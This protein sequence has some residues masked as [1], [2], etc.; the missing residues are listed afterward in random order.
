MSTG[1]TDAFSVAA[2][3][4]RLPL[5]LFGV[6]ALLFFFDLLRRLFVGATP[7]HRLG[8]FLW[9]GLVFG[10]AI[11]LAGIGLAMTYSILQFANFAHGDLITAGA[12]A[13]W[14]VTFVM[15][16]LGRF[17]A[18]ALVLVG[19]PASITS[20]LGIAITTE[21]LAIL[22]GLVAASAFAAV[23]AL[24]IDRVV[25]RP[26]RTQ[27]GIALLIASVG[28]ALALRQFIRI[29]YQPTTP[30]V[31]SSS[32]VP[33]VSIPLGTGTVSVN[34]H[35]VTLF[36]GAA[37]L[38]VAVH[39]LLQYTKLGTAMRAMADNEDL[40]QVTGIPTERVVFY[41]WLIG[42]ALTGA[43]G[44]LLALEQGFLD[45]TLG[46][47]LLLVIFAGVI[48]GG[49]G[50]VYG[51]IAG[52]LVIGIVSELSTIWIPAEFTTLA[53]FTIMIVVLLVRPQGIFGGVTSV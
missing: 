40:A 38:M 30:P 14:S 21:P 26:M 10:M 23:L 18:E 29:V 53:A 49:I 13:G 46:W 28:V 1:E 7:P 24:G 2:L 35:E 25:F 50:S 22:V 45:L 19:E 27:S 15:V 16:G 34:A 4:E 48:L 51:A 39:V 8:V 31:V 47:D 41:T 11:G 32:A 3:R 20:D 43:A 52:G 33:S 9:E 5:V 44:Y 12:F 17:A 6:L 36:V 42:G 37:M